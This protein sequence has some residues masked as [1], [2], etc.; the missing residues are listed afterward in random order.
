MAQ[1]MFSKIPSHKF[2]IPNKLQIQISNGQMDFVSKL[3]NW[4]LFGI[5]CLGFGASVTPS[6]MRYAY[7]HK[8]KL[9]IG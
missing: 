3:W 5:W 7:F 6:C 9:E 1:G 2:Q 8:A 4:K